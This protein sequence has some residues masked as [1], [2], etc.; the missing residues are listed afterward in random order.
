METVMPRN[1]FR[2]ALDGM[3]AARQRQANRMVA[4]YLLSLDD[5][6]LRRAGLR[7]TD[8]R[9]GRFQSS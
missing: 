1:P 9:N 5:E 4:G 8:V 6:S 7:R 2:A 3:V